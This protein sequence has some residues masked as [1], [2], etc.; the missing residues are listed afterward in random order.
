MFPK[1]QP[2]QLNVPIVGA[3]VTDIGYAGP[4]IVCHCSCEAKTLL[5]IN[6]FNTAV[7]CP[8]CKRCRALK[9]FSHDATTQQGMIE[10]SEVFVPE[11]AAV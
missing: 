7:R 2:P 8:A 1:I 9:S 6:G 3:P 5:I 4:Q 10:V 11:G